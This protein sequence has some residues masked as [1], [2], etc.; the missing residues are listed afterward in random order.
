MQTYEKR[1]Y[2]SRRKARGQ[3]GVAT[4][5]VAE[6]FDNGYYHAHIL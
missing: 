2:E 5:E 1:S 4:N 3:H 6:L